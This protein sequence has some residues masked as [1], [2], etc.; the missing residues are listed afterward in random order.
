MGLGVAGS[1]VG[2]GEGVVVA[3]G[4]GVSRCREGETVGGVTCGQGDDREDHA[5]SRYGVTMHGSSSG[6]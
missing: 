2:E 3:V 4:D 5:H 6:L 1:G